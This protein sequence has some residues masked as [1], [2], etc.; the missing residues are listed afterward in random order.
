M[1]PLWAEPKNVMLMGI[2]GSHAHGTYIPP[3]HPLGIDDVDV[4]VV[5]AQ[6]CDYYLGLRSYGGGNKKWGH[7]FEKTSSDLDVVVYDI[8]KF[9]S[10]LMKGNPNVQNW[11]WSPEDCYIYKSPS[12]QGLFAYREAFISQRVLHSTAGYAK[13]Q[14]YKMTHF[15]RR[16]YMGRKRKELVAKYGFDQKNA[17][18][19]I[20]L[21]HVGINLAQGK[22]I[23]VRLE[24]EQAEEVKEIKRGKKRLLEIQ[25]RAEVLFNKFN[26]LR[27]KSTLPE[28]PSMN[29]C[30]DLIV[31][32]I[33]WREVLGK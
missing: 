4:F 27:E 11:L 24:G 13:A 31:D 10:L 7:H 17:A 22:G 16:G 9:G 3:E 1:L 19:C 12:T 29:E 8:R 28:T 14:I 6:P 32:T 26:A 2:R 30:S 23:T 33:H 18:H 5:T 25:A 20:R 15:E 21:L